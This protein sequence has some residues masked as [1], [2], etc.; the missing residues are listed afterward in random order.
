MNKY[1]YDKVRAD[2]FQ[3]VSDIVTAINKGDT[4]ELESLVCSSLYS[5]TDDIPVTK[6]Y[7]KTSEI[8]FTYKN[9]HFELEYISRSDKTVVFCTQEIADGEEFKEF[10]VPDV[11]LYGS[12][13][14]MFKCF[15]RGLYKDMLDKWIDTL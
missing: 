13:E 8:D 3:R 9:L 1:D 14:S 2:A 10:L 7:N 15:D 5:C 4:N 12:P 11:W 6:W